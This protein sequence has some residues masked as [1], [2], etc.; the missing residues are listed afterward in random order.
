[1]RIMARIAK[2][3]AAHE[4]RMNWAGY[5]AHP[6]YDPDVFYC[7]PSWMQAEKLALYKV[8]RENP[9]AV[10]F[11]CVDPLTG[12]PYH[13]EQ[14]LITDLM[15][16][17]PKKPTVVVA[18]PD[19]FKYA[20]PDG[21]P[22][23]YLRWQE[24]STLSPA[25]CEAL[26]NTLKEHITFDRVETACTYGRGFTNAKPTN[27]IIA[28]IWAN[29]RFNAGVSSR[30]PITCFFD[31]EDGISSVIGRRISTTN[32]QPILVFLEEKSNQLVDAVGGDRTA[33]VGKYSK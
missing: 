11:R 1:M 8:F 32:L 5:A 30:V 4:L 7:L 26:L 14:A 20:V 17:L 19:S 2:E 25:E 21:V 16:K 18:I 15:A 3:K 24:D 6:D 28:F 22:L 12:I 23:P 9:N 27:G 31:L 13:P 33:G 10:A 29:A